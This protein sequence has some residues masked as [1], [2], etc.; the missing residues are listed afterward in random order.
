MDRFRPLACLAVLVPCLLAASCGPAASSGGSPGTVTPAAS[1]SPSPTPGLQAKVVEIGVLPGGYPGDWLVVGLVANPHDEPIRVEAIQVQLLARAG[2]SMAEQQV[3]PAIRRLAPDAQAP[4]AALFRDVPGA[5][6]AQAQAGAALADSFRPA[7]LEVEDLELLPDPGGGWTIFGV[8]ANPSSG[9][10][11]IDGLALLAR[12]RTR[13][14]VGLAS[15]A[16]YPACMPAG[17]TSLIVAHLDGAEAE[18]ALEPY[19][20]AAVT[21]RRMTT[22]IVVLDDPQLVWDRQGNP[23]VV[24]AIGNT[25]RQAQH[26]SLLVEL[27]WQ[28]EPL[29]SALVSPPLPLEPDEQRGFTAVDFPGWAARLAAVGGL[30]EE[31]EVVAWVDPCRSQASD[32]LRV[33]LEL[34][35]TQFEPIGERLFVRGQLHN[36]TDSPAV[37]PSVLADARTTAG[38]LLS[39]GWLTVGE[40][41][42]AGETEE[43]LLALPWPPRADPGLAEFD[44]IG[45]GLAE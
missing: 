6:E 8:L 44:F 18:V 36:G 15:G 26:A 38:D 13:H 11:T 14:S 5:V 22:P 19:I 34:S 24:G 35:I 2:E 20:D 43:F 1:G 17:E 16:I 45:A 23:F 33:L 7:A 3:A 32:G 25:G 21:T 28:G 30:P 31:M 37:N 29:T 10:V 12:D 39:A 42:G 9:P 40:R 27:R 41:L 4:F